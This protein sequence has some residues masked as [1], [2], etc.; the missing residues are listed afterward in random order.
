MQYNGALR[1]QRYSTVA[2]PI[3]TCSQIHG[4]WTVRLPDIAAHAKLAISVSPPAPN[5]AIDP[6][7]TCVV[8][9]R[10]DGSDEQV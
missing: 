2:F 8:D 7:S 5:T 9:S 1:L 3:P 6:H 10:G 4:H